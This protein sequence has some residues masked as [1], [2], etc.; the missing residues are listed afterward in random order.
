MSTHIMSDCSAPTAAILI[1]GNEILTGRT[2][3]RNTPFL[4]QELFSL[5]IRVEEVRVIP[6]QEDRIVTSVRELSARYTYVVSTGG[7][8][9]THDD[10]TALSMAKAFDRAF[11]LNNEA[12]QILLERYGDQYT[13]ARRR[14]AMM[15]DGV[16]LVYNPAS[17][18]PGFIIENVYV[19]PGVPDIMQS[20][21]RLLSQQITPGPTFLSESV[22]LHQPES[23]VSDAL[24]Q[25]QDR[26]PTVEIG[27]YPFFKNGAVGTCIVV[28]T[29]LQHD[30]DH[31]IDTLKS[32]SVL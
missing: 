13:T 24:S 25:L 5:G 16:K 4:T 22:V 10:I 6:D 26:Y 18:A 8:G 23:A 29:S 28:R 9:P 15:P 20:M 1:I 2:V 7:L 3:D 27:S 30:L 32:W 11:T 21:F 12:D 17:A 14:M 19:L 31:V